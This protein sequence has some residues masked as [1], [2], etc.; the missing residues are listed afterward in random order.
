MQPCG[1]T[2]IHETWADS[3]ACIKI[4]VPLRAAWD[5]DSV[6][7]AYEPVWAIGTGKV[8]VAIFILLPKHG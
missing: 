1:L 2:D 7:L 6:V 3:R 5:W 8:G 4:E